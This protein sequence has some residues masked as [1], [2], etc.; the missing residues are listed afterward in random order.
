MLYGPSKEHLSDRGVR[1]SFN[2]RVTPSGAR[3]AL[4]QCLKVIHTTA[5]IATTMAPMIAS[6]RRSKTNPKPPLPL[7]PAPH[8]M[9]GVPSR[10]GQPPSRAKP[11]CAPPLDKTTFNATYNDLLTSA[12]WLKELAPFRTS[13]RKQPTAAVNP[14]ATMKVKRVMRFFCSSV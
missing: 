6:V 9:F 3:L 12:G 8:M 11:W 1:K 4:D 10:L 2:L 5:P 14:A 7:I 13:L